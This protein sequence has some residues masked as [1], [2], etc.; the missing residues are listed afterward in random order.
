MT[1]KGIIVDRG[2]VHS[3]A[4]PPWSMTTPTR[5]EATAMTPAARRSEPRLSDRK[6]RPTTSAGA[7]L[8]DID[9]AQ[10]P[11]RLKRSVLREFVFHIEREAAALAT[12]AAAI[13]SSAD[14]LDA[15]TLA[16][17]IWASGVSAQFDRTVP[18]A[19]AAFVDAL[20]RL[21]P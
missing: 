6:W 18:E 14:A 5:P 19:A 15:Q 7:A 20:A 21:R 11:K 8:L 13:D 12:E 9:E 17:A 3:R 1:R 16:Q 10:L 4:E 2:I